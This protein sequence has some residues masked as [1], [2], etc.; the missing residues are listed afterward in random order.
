MKTF[1]NNKLLGIL[2]VM[3]LAV[4]VPLTVSL[5]MRSQDIRQRASEITPSVTPKP[6]AKPKKDV[7]KIQ[8]Q[9]FIDTNKNGK[10]DN[11][12]SFYTGGATVSITG[13]KNDSKVSNTKGSVSFN[14]IP[15][16]TYTVTLSVP[17]NFQTTT[18]NPKT[19]TIRRA[20]SGTNS[21]NKPVL[22]R[23]G[24]APQISPSP[25]P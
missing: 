19:A 3:V 12:E 25:T 18:K 17:A 7:R 16:G 20:K 4:S 9:I 2:T 24:I 10:K 14:N 5:A 21:K 11:G 15:Y 23:F 8:G 22:V 6:T 1:K 13:P